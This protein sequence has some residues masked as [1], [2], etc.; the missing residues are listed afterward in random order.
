M[1]LTMP[2]VKR[3]TASS[4]ISEIVSCANVHVNGDFL[5]MFGMI[6]AMVGMT[7][8]SGLKLSTGFRYKSLILRLTM[9]RIISGGVQ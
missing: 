3:C 1:L 9:Q 4:V 6:L 7:C 8:L 2:F 5:V